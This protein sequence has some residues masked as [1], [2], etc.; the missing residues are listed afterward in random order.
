[1]NEFLIFKAGQYPQGTVTKDQLDAFAASFNESKDEIPIFVGHRYYAGSDADEL[2]HGWIKTIRVDGAGKVW[3]TDY[4][5]DDFAREA[6]AK[7]QLK[8]CSVE[9]TGIGSPDGVEVTGLALLGRTQPA[10]KATFLPALFSRLFGGAAIQDEGGPAAF[11]AMAIDREGLG[12]TEGAGDSQHFNAAGK[13]GAA[14]SGGR[15]VPMTDAEKQEMEKL[16]AD[17]AAAEGR[18]AAYA[19]RETERAVTERKTEAERFFF[20]LRDAGKMTPA[21]ADSAVAYEAAIEDEEPR[22]KFRELFASAGQIVGGE[23]V[24]SKDKAPPA[25]EGANEVAAIKAFQAEKAIKT[26][27]EAA[28][29]YYRAKRKE[30]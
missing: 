20:G 9:I 1:M 22:K 14:A 27:G 15:E 10:V 12:L 7:G 25:P 13:D 29:L 19:R 6:L 16:R 5:I 21:Q 18:V 23:H 24:A 3:A 26:F 17:L 30:G 4:E 8:K 11:E 2:A 28:E